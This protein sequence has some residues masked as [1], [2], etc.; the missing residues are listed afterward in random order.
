MDNIGVRR[1]AEPHNGEG[2][3]GKRKKWLTIGIPVVLVLAIGGWFLYQYLTDGKRITSED[4]EIYETLIQYKIA[5]STLTS[6]EKVDV[7]V[8]NVSY[9]NK[10]GADTIAIYFLEGTYN[11]EP[12]KW[13]VWK[14]LNEY[15]YWAYTINDCRD[16]CPAPTKIESM[17]DWD[18]YKLLREKRMEIGEKIDTCKCADVK[19]TVDS[20]I[21]NNITKEEQKSID[22]R[23][24]GM[25]WQT[26]EEG[27]EIIE[28]SIDLTIENGE[29]YKVNLD[30]NAY[31]YLLSD[32]L[33]GW[34]RY[35]EEYTET[36]EEY[37]FLSDE[38]IDMIDDTSSVDY[39]DYGC[40]AC[41]LSYL[42]GTFPPAE[43]GETKT[44]LSMMAEHSM[45]I[46][47]LTHLYAL[48][49][50]E[51]SIFKEKI[52]REISQLK[53]LAE[54]N[55]ELLAGYM[56]GEFINRL[57]PIKILEDKEEDVKE[58]SKS[59]AE[60]EA[61]MGLDLD[62][63]PS[64]KSVA[65]CNDTSQTAVY[66]LVAEDKTGE[67]YGVYIDVVRTKDHTEYLEE[68]GH[69]GANVGD[70]M[71]EGDFFACIDGKKAFTVD[72]PLEQT[73]KTRGMA[74]T[75][76]GTPSL[77]VT[78]V[79]GSS[80]GDFAYMYILDQG[81][82]IPLVSSGEK[83]EGVFTTTTIRK[84]GDW[85]YQF[86]VY[87][88][89]AWVYS[90]YEITINPSTYEFQLKEIALDGDGES[91]FQEFRYDPSYVY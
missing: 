28:D 18:S 3:K 74:Y 60:P 89:M 83:E 76:Q 23:K 70:H 61:S 38:M 53:N 68:Y 55:S 17:E 62:R 73:N 67:H 6:P 10:I 52:N 54:K 46:F 49:G 57:E 32:L 77:L 42:A 16:G 1:M 36:I 45:R 47:E 27:L 12:I 14:N 37:G 31:K 69:A 35:L 2:R 86:M 59:D 85:K 40:Y 43:F 13:E 90:L 87:D 33:K 79:F 20:I 51:E 19:A 34:A 48:H 15:G 8:D 50:E 78:T 24:E 26:P 21:P 84:S 71:V 72:L 11:E 22:E 88:N 66:S 58:K 63:L 4:K 91:I 30:A 29:F 81:R 64:V 5:E 82:L 65:N 39:D 56:V 80:S 44:A 7:K 9:R 75:V 41:S 25:Q